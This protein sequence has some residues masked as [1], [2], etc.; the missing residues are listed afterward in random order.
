LQSSAFVS[1]PWQRGRSFEHSKHKMKLTL[2]HTSD[3]IQ[4][5]FYDLLRLFFGA[6]LK[7]SGLI[8]SRRKFRE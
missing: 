2:T 8:V 1:Q 5:T 6:T 7:Q 3:Y 4:L